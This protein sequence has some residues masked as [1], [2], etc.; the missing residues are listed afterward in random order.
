MLIG[1]FETILFKLEVLD[2]RAREKAGV[3]TPTFGAPIPVLLTFDAAVEVYIT[4][5][6]KTTKP[7]PVW[8]CYF[9]TQLQIICYLAIGRTSI[10][11]C[12]SYCL[13]DRPFKLYPFNMEFF[14]PSTITGK[15]RYCF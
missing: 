1:R 4:F 6:C 9:Y 12:I 13:L 2:H 10:V 14:N 5:S 7:T 15:K 11:D 8:T 3:I